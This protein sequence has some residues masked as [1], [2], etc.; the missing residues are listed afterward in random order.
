[1]NTVEKNL[2]MRDR[3]VNAPALEDAK[4]SLEKEHTASNWYDY[5]MALSKAKR[6]DDAIDAYSQGLVE[7]PF[8]ALLYFGRGRRYMGTSYEQAIADFT[9]AIQLEGAVNLYW[10]YRAVCHNMCGN[11]EQAIYDFRQALRYAQPEDCYSMYDWIFSSYVE[12]GDMESARKLL[13]DAPDDQDVP[14]MDWDYKCRVRLYKGLRK[15][16]E[17]LNLEEIR[18]HVSDS[19][20]DLKLD[21]VTLRYGMFIYYTYIGDLEKGNEQLL[22][23]V[24]DPFEGAF[25]TTK[26]RQY[27]KARG[28][29]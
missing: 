12:M 4:A 19:D 20:D 13:Q 23:I 11:F 7:F 28:L 27:A 24:K 5:G 6:S 1:M 14:D 22:A 29:I 10:Y 26:A 16:E 25:A 18:Q 9:M 17:M 21:V 2:M 3:L 15:P 8:S